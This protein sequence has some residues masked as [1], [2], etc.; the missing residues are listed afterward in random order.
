V[1][2]F[3]RLLCGQ[4]RRSLVWAVQI[5]CPPLQGL[6]RGNIYAYFGVTITSPSTPRSGVER[7]S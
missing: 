7:L 5:S 3:M 6:V 4:R 2:I 1:D